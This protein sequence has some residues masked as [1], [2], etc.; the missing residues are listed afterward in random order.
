MT[1]TLLKNPDQHVLQPVGFHLSLT[2]FIIVDGYLNSHLFGGQQRMVM[3]IFFTT[4][5]K[6]HYRFTMLR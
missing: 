6:V 4:Y 1:G 3:E 2:V 5:L